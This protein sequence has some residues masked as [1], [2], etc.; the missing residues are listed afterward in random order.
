MT[1]MATP[2]CNPSGRFVLRSLDAGTGT[3]GPILRAA[4]SGV[5]TRIG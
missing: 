1:F 5:T 2:T 4:D 3:L